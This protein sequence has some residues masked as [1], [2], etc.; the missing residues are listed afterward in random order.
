M[1][2]LSQKK[3]III[4]DQKKKNKAISLSKYP[5]DKIL[6]KDY[7][8]IEI[9]ND[10]K[11]F[12]CIYKINNAAF[13]PFL[14]YLLWK[15]PKSKKEYTD[16][17]VFPFVKYHKDKTPKQ[18]ADSTVKKITNKN[19]DSK[20]FIIENNHV[21]FFFHDTSIADNLKILKRN[22]QQWWVT[23]DEICN[24]R[25]IL[26]F[27]IHQTVFNVF[28]KHPKLIHLINE[29]NLPIE[30]PT[31]AYYGGYTKLLPLT[32]V[33]GARKLRSALYGPFYYFGDYNSALR[34]AGWS[35]SY[36][37]WKI[38]NK[39]ITDMEGKWKTGGIIRFILFLGN[40]KVLTNHVDDLSNTHNSK[41]HKILA[42]LIDRNSN[43][44]EK[45][46]SLCVGRAPLSNN[47]VF[48]QS[49]QFIVKKF[50]QQ[51]SLSIHIV[52]M[53]TF[54]RTWDP[55]HDKYYIQ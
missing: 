14:Q 27:P 47:Y 25:N 40:T 48:R 51:H 39:Y 35:T 43:W 8:H 36:N 50:K 3:A 13:K 34:Y 12:I 31:V 44:S 4:K 24:H 23:I 53:K 11:I 22:N 45:Y 6:R 15:Y 28:F 9:N 5:I 41:S 21:Y 42:N 7:S 38:D 17:V 30:V 54:L 32:A 33:F 46:D 10:L 52:D 20:G 37:P 16:L 19:L 1:D 29:K 18:L 55:T 49:T 2:T 26:K